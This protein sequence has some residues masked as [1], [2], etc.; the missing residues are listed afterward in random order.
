MKKSFSHFTRGLN[1]V[2]LIALFSCSKIPEM[3][4]EEIEIAKT[5][6]TSEL[7]EKTIS[8]PWKGQK[9]KSG[10]V[11][12]IWHTS[13]TADPKSFNLLIAERDAS[14]ASILA[15]MHDYLVDYDYIKKEFVPLCATP[16]VSV[17]EKKQTLT[18]KYTL[19]DNLFWSYYDSDKKI[20]VTADDVV[21]WY[22][23]IEGDE[24][25]HSS[26]YNSQFVEMPDG[27]IERITIE[28][29]NEKTF[30]FHYPRI[31]S[32]PLLSSNRNFGPKFLYEEAKRNGGIK[33]VQDLLSIATDPK[34]I[35]SMGMWFL[36]W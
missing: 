28:K 13:I 29:L 3:T 11:G 31:D 19:R 33:G 34:T 35:P 30:A 16:E 27:S 18:V 25:F 17:D 6:G 26:A 9:Y 23:E 12:G 8:K 36:I 10:K 7:I 24:N 20:P 21:F 32:N 2:F 1:A 14:T 4:L 22:D 15:H 5:S